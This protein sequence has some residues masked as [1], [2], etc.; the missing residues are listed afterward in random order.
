MMLIAAKLTLKPNTMRIFEI[1][2]SPVFTRQS[3]RCPDL[4]SDCLSLD[5]NT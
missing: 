1:A 2:V 3:A 5:E 4:V